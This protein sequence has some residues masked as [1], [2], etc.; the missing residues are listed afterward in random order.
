MAAQVQALKGAQA[1]A[2]R[3]GKNGKSAAPRP[4]SETL[5]PGLRFVIMLAIMAAT[6]M[7][8]LDTSIV[9]VA[10]PD[11][12]GN[13]G[14]TLDQI[15]WVSTG[16][17][18]ANV[19]VLPLTG[20]LS[21]YFGRKKYL[22]YSVILFTVAS[23]F[24]GTS[25]TLGELVLWRVMQ[26]AGGA[27]FLSTAQATLMEIYP[28]ARRGFAQAMFG[29]GVIA[30][31]TLGPTLGGW[32]TD[33]FT[34]PWIFFVNLPVGIIAATLTVLFLPDSP[35]AGERRSA[36]FVGIGF[37]A[38]GLGSLQTVLERGEADNWFESGFITTLAF[39]SAI[40]I[41]LFI[42]W[43]LRPA[44]KHPAV[45]LHVVTNRNLAAGTVYAF[46]LGL[47]LYGGVFVLPQ[48]LQNVQS[49]TAEQSGLLLM[50]GG[51]ASA[52]MMPVVGQLSNRVD[53]RLMIG[54][55]MILF[56][57]SMYMFAGR[58][59]LDMPDTAMFWP[60]AVRGAAIGLQF[61]P[62]SLLALGTL[63]TRNLADG[64]GFYNLF[65]QLGGSFG[66]AILATI[67][68]RRMH[69]HY[70]RL[71][72]HL[73]PYDPTTQQRLLAIQNSLVAQGQSPTVAHQSAYQVL[74]NMVTGQ[75][76]VMTYVDVFKFMGWVG[77]G[78]LLL[79]FLF[80]RT[81]GRGGATAAA[82]H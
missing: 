23:F 22:T 17:I 43:E 70:Q 57:I 54:V 55:G 36:D 28:P 40:G 45:N 5:T 12:M 47:V 69:F 20:W 3:N 66:I 53:K 1:H 32:I 6:M 60:L 19:I 82:A 73:S 79:L 16:Y 10:L 62:L 15:G 27:A 25:R 46:A 65:R 42:W 74:S 8:V 14:A 76:A 72:E 24:C 68:D 77:L 52:C 50:P 71:A 58:L 61:V 2:A 75:A 41:L 63:P 4:L 37:L 49:H 44:N 35:A 39:L 67:V 29:I 33:R 7:E 21:D 9:N 51:L 81:K 34:W 31:P 48:F 30:A 13:L 78:A 56:V 38:L 59:N 26:G 64:A 80:Q 11:M 18:I